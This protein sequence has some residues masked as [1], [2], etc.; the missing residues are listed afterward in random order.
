MG[1][2][3]AVMVQ[4]IGSRPIIEVITYISRATT[5]TQVNSVV[6]VKKKNT[7]NEIRIHVLVYRYTM[8]ERN[9]AN[10]KGTEGIE[11]RYG[12]TEVRT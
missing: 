6:S 8:L 2:S 7:N 1:K 4:G 5:G 11:E 12:K 3:S 10:F 9:G